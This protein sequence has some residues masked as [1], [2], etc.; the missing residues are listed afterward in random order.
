MQVAP[1]MLLSDPAHVAH[2]LTPAKA[3]NQGEKLLDLPLLWEDAFCLEIL[4]ET[5]A[6]LS[7]G[8][9]RLA[10]EF[11][12]RCVA[13]EALTAFIQVGRHIETFIGLRD[14]MRRNKMTGCWLSFRLSSLRV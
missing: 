3:L 6:T 9:Q 4:Q 5:G 12:W 11:S 1:E 8:A 7:R 13:L 14:P 10:T 2:T